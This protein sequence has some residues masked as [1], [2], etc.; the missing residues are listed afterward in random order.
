MPDDTGP[1]HLAT[2]VDQAGQR[3]PVDEGPVNEG[4]STKAGHA[5]HGRL[6]AVFVGF[7]ATGPA[8]TQ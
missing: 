6:V 3:R 7:V 8:P 1:K 5:N 2:P 4:R